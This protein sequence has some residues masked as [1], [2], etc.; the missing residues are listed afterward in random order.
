MQQ[1]AEVPASLVTWFYNCYML[2]SSQSYTVRQFHIWP[3]KQLSEI[4]C[5][6]SQF[7]PHL[8]Y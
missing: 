5:T 8:L 3:S 1:R 7:K 2:S 4:K 6:N